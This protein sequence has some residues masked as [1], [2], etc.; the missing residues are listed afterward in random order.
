MRASPHISAIALGLLWLGACQFEKDDEPQ[1]TPIVLKGD[2]EVLAE[3]GGTP[4]TRYD[5][6]ASLR[7]TFSDGTR[8]GMGPELENRAIESLVQTR[9]MA[10]AQEKSLDA[11]AL[12]KLEKRVAAYREELLVKQY[13][14]QNTRPDP[15]SHQMVREH[16]EQNAAR[17]GARTVRHYELI[18]TDGKLNA[19]QRASLGKALAGAGEKQDWQAW[20]QELRAEGHRVGVRH[21][22]DDDAVLDPKLRALIDGLDATEVSKLTFIR[23]RGYLV[24]VTRTE[25]TPAKPLAEVSGEIRRQLAPL[26]LKAAVQ[27]AS[28]KVLKETEVAYR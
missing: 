10:L 25:E 19:M 1:E 23:G 8:K 18:T 7:D 27:E 24:R 15:I 2:D 14:S 6:E 4:I 20:T 11:E 5:L 3:V 17:Y 26:R 13:L 21:G 28:K 9:A 12:A 16:Y 22:R